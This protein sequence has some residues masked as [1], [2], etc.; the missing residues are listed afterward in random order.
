MLN[1]LDD[2]PIHQT[3]EPIAHPASS[4]RNVYDRTWYNGYAA[5]GSYYFAIGMSLFPHRGILDCA[6]SVVERNGRQ[7]SFFGSRRAPLE[8]TEMQV[9]PFRM[10]VL[11]P[12]RRA[13][14]TL[15]DNDSGIRCE[16]TFSARTAAIEEERQTTWTGTRRTMDTTRFLQFGRWTGRIGHPDGELDL[17]AGQCHATKDRSWGTRDTAG[18]PDSGGAPMPSG[19]VCFIWAPLIWDDHVSHA[20]CIEDEHGRPLINE[21]IVAPLHESEAAVPEVG[22]SRYER[23]DRMRQRV[24]YHPGTRLAQSAEID[25][26]DIQ[27]RV[28]TISLEPMLRFQMKGLGYF[29]PEWGQGFW[30]G[31]LATGSDSFDP[32]ELDL[33]APENIHVQQV[34]RANDGERSGIGVLEQ[35]VFGPY[36]PAG[37]TDFVDVPQ[38]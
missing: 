7:H 33:L 15:D 24:S 18:E 32:A 3:A 1:K 11:E 13:R 26:I 2:F 31:E 9:G 6:L 12:L 10:E 8:R 38:R 16:L 28:R 22:D 27:D 37:F 30:K 5:D 36:A 4:D 17:S 23:L 21:A 29:H 20:V 19:G 25:L 35:T 14:V 34:V